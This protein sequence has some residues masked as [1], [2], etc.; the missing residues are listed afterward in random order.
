MVIDHFEQMQNYGFVVM[1]PSTEKLVDV[2][3]MDC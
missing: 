2:S 1:F 3:G